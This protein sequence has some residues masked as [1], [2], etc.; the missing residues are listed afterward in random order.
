MCLTNETQ[1]SNSNQR[2][3][4]AG[5]LVRKNTKAQAVGSDSTGGQDET[6]TK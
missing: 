6:E 4:E 2:C 3:S 5:Q 1:L